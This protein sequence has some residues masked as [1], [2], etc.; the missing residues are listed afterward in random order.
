MIKRKA[1]REILD[2]L[3]AFPAVAILG[4]RQVGKTTLAKAIAKKLKKD[5]L[6]F[7]LEN[8]RDE[9]T[10]R[11]DA[12]SL[13]EEN[14]AKLVIIDEVQR[15]PELFTYL[16]PLIDS[17][18]KKGRFLLSG[19]ASPN[20]VKGV[21]ESLAGR[22]Y[23][24]E[25]TP[26]GL[27][28]L[29]VKNTF[30]KLWFRGGF[31]RALTARTDA[32]FA[33]WMDTFIDTYTQ[34]DL[35]AIFGINLSRQVIYNFWRML[36][37]CHSGIYNA[38]MFARSLGITSPTVTRYLDYLEGA[39]LVRRLPAYFMNARKRLVK[40][41]KIYIS[42]SGILHRLLGVNSFSDLKGNPI[43]GASWEGFVAEQ[44]RRILPKGYD[45]FYYRTQ[46]GAEA[47]LVI[48]RSLK[49]VSCIE[50]KYSNAPKISPGFYNSIADLGTKDNYVITP[51][52]DTLRI[53]GEIRVMGLP[54]F[55]KDFKTT[56]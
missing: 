15:M 48:T 6:Y 35:N 17:N 25:I 14:S 34:R 47:D 21:S 16:R 42:D 20:L 26:I 12:Y 32:Q 43:V 56:K 2:K 45:L 19:S 54:A 55:L 50:I 11:R 49:P 22:I 1:Q 30:E 33:E 40:A 39:Y 7:D 51:Q 46:N 3:G 36:A 31:P 8:P 28:E 24:A 4:A 52:A 38:E 9:N 29:P 10:L 18:K 37:H 44:V 41:P 5:I 53:S 23:Y 13:L 27:N